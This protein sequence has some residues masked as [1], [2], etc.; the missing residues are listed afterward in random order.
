[1]KRVA[2]SALFAVTTLLAGCTEPIFKSFDIGDGTSK[3]I[4]AK[5]RVILVKANA[6]PYGNDTWVCAEPSPDALTARAAA[7][8]VSG[9]T[10]KVGGALSGSATEAA[11]S[12]GLRTQTIQLLR[13]GYYRLC[14]AYMN[15]AL[16]RE[17]YNLAL[18]S[19]PEVMVSLLAVD[20]I[21]G[22]PRPPAVIVAPNGATAKTTGATEGGT[23]S[24]EASTATG[25]AT[26]SIETITAQT[27]KS[28]TT[29][30]VN[31]IKTIVAMSS[32]TSF[33]SLCLAYMA[34]PGFFN[35]R[36]PHGEDSLNA[37]RSLIFNCERF[38]P[39]YY[40]KVLKMAEK[41]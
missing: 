33:A 24:G 19:L 20:A 23:P 37:K 31:L 25:T 22:T 10:P 5:Q 7:A 35:N 1:M 13:D 2:V 21:A 4:D 8:A 18:V 26:A 16:S 39:R 12:I 15:G 41:T 36:I 28:L 27:A 38:L 30:E 32:E 34:D 9:G 17:Q 6:G 14:E 29:D 11:A 40:E 3:S